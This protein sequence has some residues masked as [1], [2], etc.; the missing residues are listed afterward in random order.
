MAGTAHLSGHVRWPGM[1]TS[2][3]YVYRTPTG[4]WY[5]QCDLCGESQSEPN[6]SPA[7]REAFGL[8]LAHVPEC[9]GYYTEDA[10]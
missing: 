5:W 6:T 2:G 1:P 4:R 10:S 8:A 9:I 7:M 3:R